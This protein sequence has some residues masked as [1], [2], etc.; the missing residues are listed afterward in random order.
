[1][2]KSL[3]KISTEETY[4]NMIKIMH[5]E[6]IANVI[7][8]GEKLKTFPLRLRGQECSLSPLLFNIVLEGLATTTKQEK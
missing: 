5:E 8:N 4:F 2:K 6:L 1:M 7:F 3:I